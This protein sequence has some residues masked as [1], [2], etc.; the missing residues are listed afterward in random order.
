MLVGQ[1]YIVLSYASKEVL[2]YRDRFFIEYL[3]F[4]NFN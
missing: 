2:A 1:I 4:N 3:F